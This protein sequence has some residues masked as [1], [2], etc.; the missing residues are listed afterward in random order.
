T[1]PHNSNVD[2]VLTVQA[3]STEEGGNSATTSVAVPV[4]V[5][6]VADLP[7]LSATLGAPVE[8]PGT[9][10]ITIT[11]MGQVSAGYNNSY[12]Y[13]VKDANGNPTDGVI[14]WDNAKNDV[15]DTFTIEGVDPDSIGFFVIPD[16]DSRNVLLGD[17]TPVHF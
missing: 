15:G 10:D 7:T 11:N 3:T 16:G 4:H 6:G 8:I 2:F 12:G 14:I 9:T 5:T 17:N 1:P 13:Y